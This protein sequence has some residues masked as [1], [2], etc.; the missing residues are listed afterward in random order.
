MRS[1]LTYITKSRLNV[2]LS[3]GLAL[4]GDCT[5]CGAS[6]AFPDCSA[7]RACP[8]SQTETPWCRRLLSERTRRGQAASTVFSQL[9][10]I[11]RAQY[12]P[13]GMFY[14]AV[15]PLRVSIPAAGQCSAE[16]ALHSTQHPAKSF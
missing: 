1:V 10:S 13:R 11:G 4:L 14:P 16:I 12:C 3:T 7:F 5:A 8:W 15:L 2:E 9:R 6:P